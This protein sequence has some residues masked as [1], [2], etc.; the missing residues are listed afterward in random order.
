MSQ[1]C[2][3]SEHWSSGV[4]LG[5]GSGGRGAAWQCQTGAQLCSAPRSVGAARWPQPGKLRAAGATG[6]G[7]RRIRLLHFLCNSSSGLLPGSVAGKSMCSDSIISQ[8]AL[9]QVHCAGKGDISGHVCVD[10]IYT[11]IYK[12]IYLYFYY[13]LSSLPL[14]PIPTFQHWIHWNFTTFACFCENT[15]LCLRQ[16]ANGGRQGLRSLPLFSSRYGEECAV[17]NAS[18]ELS[19]V[20]AK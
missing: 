16:A 14:H 18:M 9:L 13:T 19:C 10:Q 1:K 11:Y 15:H 6:P 17:N 5:L 8:V 2:G 4:E 12:T 20:G 3:L 7:W